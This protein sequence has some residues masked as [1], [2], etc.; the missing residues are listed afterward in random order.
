MRA[1]KWEEDALVV[2][3]QTRLP[4]ERSYRRC[5]GHKMVADA[6]RELAVRGAPAIGVAAAYGMALGSLEY[7]GKDQI[8]LR[9]HLNT[10]RKTLAA[11]RPT[12]INLFWALERIE[13]KLNQLKKES[14]AEIQAA[15]I[16]EAQLME[17]ED[18]EINRALSCHGNNIIPPQARILTH[19]NTGALATCGYGTAL[20]VVRAAHE[21]G[22]NVQVIATE[23]RPLLQG[24]R[25]TAFEL[26]DAE[27]PVTLITDSMAGW[28]LYQGLVDLV[29]FG[30]D[31]IAANGDTAN[32]IGSYSLAVVARENGVPVF[33]AAP[34]STFDLSLKNGSEI[35]VEERSPKEVTQIGPMQ[36]APPGVKAFN[37]AFDV[38]PYQYLNGIIT[39]AGILR[40]PFHCAIRKALVNKV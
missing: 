15:L 34:R 33:V 12:A 21:G 16:E 2:L 11:T 29:I 8:K 10:V 3:D 7:K 26:L 20:G 17:R 23:T 13:T 30:A 37:P 24:S 36:M 22:K 25:L 19:C 40:P 1:M 14:V 39:E 28:V 35:P 27:I 31:R 5:T 4:L 6:I 9:D 18:I 32:K 38:T